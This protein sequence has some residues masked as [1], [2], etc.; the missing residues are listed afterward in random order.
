[1]ID[2]V[3]SEAPGVQKPDLVAFN[4]NCW[5]AQYVKNHNKTWWDT[6]SLPVDV[7]HF[8]TKHKQ[9]DMYCQK[10]CNPAMFK[11]LL[12][13]N[14]KTQKNESTAEQT[15]VWLGGF[16]SIWCEMRTVFF[17]FFLDQMILLWNEVL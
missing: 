4:S 1:M 12:V 6:I 2:R 9:T 14:P 16:H 7:F 8:R 17:D 3:N 13:Y 10:W 5:L 11:E 15:N